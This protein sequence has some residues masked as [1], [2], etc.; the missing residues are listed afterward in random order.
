MSHN[1]EHF[2]FN[3][4][5]DKVKVEADLNNYAAM[6]NRGEGSTGLGSKIRW[7][8]KIC[9]SEADAHD[10]IESVDKGWYDQV[11]VRFRGPVETAKT[12]DLQNRL[13][14]ARGKAKEVNAVVHFA[15]A[16]AAFI[17]CPHCK[18]KI[19]QPYIKTNF[20][21]VC[22][23]DL[24]PA[25]ALDKVQKAAQKCRDLEEKLRQAERD[26]AQKG[27]IK[28]LVKIEYHT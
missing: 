28:W 23:A 16:K 18:S 5:A 11:A 14:V 13:L 10:Y 27:D 15:S 17:S 4:N 12:R 19:A 3:D 24:R 25:S 6:S 7:L 1:I 2:I 26:A 20:C 21:P 9:D 22:H 8:N